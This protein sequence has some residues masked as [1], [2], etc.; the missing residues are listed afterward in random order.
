M[1]PMEMNRP[2]TGD[3]P[4]TERDASHIPPYDTLL[5]HIDAVIAEWRALV[6]QEPWAA[7]PPARLTDSL[8]EILPKLFRLAAL[9]R[10]H[11]DQELA[12]LIAQSHGYFRR[13][14]AVPLAAVAEEWNHLRRAC[15]KVIQTMGA[16]EET[17]LA[18]FA[19]LD[20]LIDDAIGLTLRGYYAPELDILRGRGLE[21]RDGPLERR[22]NPSD[23]RS[24][25]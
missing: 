9:G 20:P 18:A 19:K 14:D 11:A 16:N 25:R 12:E 15:W 23:R 10:L 13:H 17:A 22:S 1:E 24:S 3:G 2:V 21:R 6:A 5:G 4:V 8:P 7:I